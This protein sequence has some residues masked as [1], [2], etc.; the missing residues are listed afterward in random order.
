MQIDIMIAIKKGES[1]TENLNTFA[2]NLSNLLGEI[3][4]PENIHVGTGRHYYIQPAIDGC[5]LLL[6]HYRGPLFVDMSKNDM[7]HIVEGSVSSDDYIRSANWLVGYYW[8]GGS[9]IGG[10]YYQP[11]SITERTADVKRYMRILRCRTLKL[12]SGYGPD[13]ETCNNCF[14]ETC[15]FSALK[16][17]TSSWE[18]EPIKEVDPRVPFFKMLLKKFESMY[19]GYTLKGF[20]CSLKD[21]DIPIDK[22][23]IRANTRWL[24][25]DP[26]S[27]M[28]WVSSSTIRGLLM[29]TV[30][31]E[32]II[33]DIHFYHSYI[34]ITS[35]D[36][37][38]KEASLDTMREVFSIPGMDR[39][40][41]VKAA[42][43][44]AKKI[45]AKEAAA[46]EADR[47]KWGIFGFLYDFFN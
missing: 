23:L 17:K 14:V 5:P 34:E 45:A 28:V 6:R 35:S 7:D 47:K 27:F 18:N 12:S 38:L 39:P 44:E 9:M 36:G 16:N 4:S 32:T 15:P 22:A 24:E 31:P 26:Y 11:I 43:E 42:A 46:K 30:D 1:M 37:Q 3:I 19:P 13:D 20:C 8:G 21:E 41:E 2:E 33:K 10:G 40:N 29:H 25:N